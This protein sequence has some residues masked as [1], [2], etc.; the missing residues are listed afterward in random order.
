M[1]ASAHKS[2]DGSVVPCL[3]ILLVSV[4]IRYDPPQLASFWYRCDRYV[5]ARIDI[6]DRIQSV[7]Q[8]T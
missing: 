5:L 1:H 7:E 4:P 2:C 6:N 8:V 3:M